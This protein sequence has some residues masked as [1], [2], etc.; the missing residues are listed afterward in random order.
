MCRHIYLNLFQKLDTERK[1]GG[2]GSGCQIVGNVYNMCV[3][4]R[5]IW[6]SLHFV[7]V[8]AFARRS[9]VAAG[10]C[11]FRHAEAEAQQVA[12]SSVVA[13]I[14]DAANHGFRQS[15]PLASC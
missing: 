10:V 4:T 13:C 8:C 1:M 7:G 6:L 15:E 12:F 9:H 5:R 2:E 11:S 3:C 14:G